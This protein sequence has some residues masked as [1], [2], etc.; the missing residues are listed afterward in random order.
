MKGL[1]RLLPG[2]LS[3]LGFAVTLSAVASEQ[4]V[5]P[6]L[7]AMVTRAQIEGRVT[8]WCG[9]EFRAGHP[10]AFAAAVTSAAGQ[11][12]Y[13]VLDSDGTVAELGAFEGEPDLSCYTPAEARKLTE[14][15]GESN[16]IEGHVA[17]RWPTTVICAFSDSTTAACWQYSPKA[18]RFVKVGGWIT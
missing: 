11:G 9:G 17:P 15:I 2:V 13:V 1:R 4:P 14:T 16:T 5:P 10:D 8:A 18:R 7:S 6:A 12:R 3:V